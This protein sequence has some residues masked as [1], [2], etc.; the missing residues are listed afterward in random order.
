MVVSS[1]TAALRSDSVATETTGK[2]G[3][4]EDPVGARESCKVGIGVG[5]FADERDE[6]VNDF[7][8]EHV[9]VALPETPPT[10]QDIS[11]RP[12]SFVRTVESHA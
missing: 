10:D 9:R 12:E 2:D 5:A 4:G 1:A 11:W 7:F 6:T 8:P 3:S